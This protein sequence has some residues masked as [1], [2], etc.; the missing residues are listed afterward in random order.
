MSSKSDKETINKKGL[1]QSVKISITSH[2]I[3]DKF[4]KEKRIS[5][6]SILDDLISFLN[7]YNFSMA[8]LD[9]RYE[10]YQMNT[11]IKENHKKITAVLKR[12]SDDFLSKIE[13]NNE[14]NLEFL[15]RAIKTLA[16][17]RAQE[18]IKIIVEQIYKLSRAL[19]SGV[20]DDRDAAVLLKET[21]RAIQEP[22]IALEPVKT[23]QP[24]EER[25]LPV[26]LIETRRVVVEGTIETFTETELIKENKKLSTK[27]WIRQP[28]SSVIAIFHNAILLEGDLTTKLN[29]VGEENIRTYFNS[30]NP[31]DPIKV[32][33]Y[34]NTYTQGKNILYK[35][36]IITDII[37]HTQRA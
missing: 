34:I 11:E 20:I 28:L 19:V 1:T 31:S 29:L 13:K 32:D 2:Q 8:I 17:I 21:L 6:Q 10:L 26:E 7:R 4:H 33:G 16:E 36:Y 25:Y 23:V 35:N 9:E 18:D 22:K 3:L 5:M 12:F 37:S 15:T 14:N 30:F 24:I 27:F